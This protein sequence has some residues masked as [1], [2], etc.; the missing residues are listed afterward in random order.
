MKLHISVLVLSVVLLVSAACS[1]G[2]TPE[3]TPALTVTPSATATA[4]ATPTATAVPTATATRT[5]P[6]PTATSLPPTPTPTPEASSVEAVNVADSPAGGQLSWVL[7]AVNRDGLTE[8][9]VARH[10]TSTFADRV[11]AAQVIALFGEFRTAVEGDWMLVQTGDETDTQMV[12]LITAGG[13]EL[14]VQIVVVSDQPHLIKELS[15]SAT[16][17][18]RDERSPEPPSL[19]DPPGSWAELQK[20]LAAEASQVGLL[21]AEVTGGS[22]QPI[23]GFQ[24]D[25]ALAI[26]SIFK[27]YV[28]GELARQIDEGLASWEESLPIREDI[29][30]FG[31]LG[32][33]DSMEDEAAGILFTLKR[34]A[35][36]MISNSDNTATDHLIHRL[37]RENV[38]ASLARLGHSD[39]ALNIPFPTARELFLIKLALSPGQRAA[40][41]ELGSEGRRTFLDTDLAGRGIGDAVANVAQWVAPV[42]IDSI[43]WFASPA[44]L[45][46]AMV[47]LHEAAS[48]PG[49]EPPVRDIL[50]INPGIPLDER[51]WPFVGFKGGSEQGVLA[52]SWLLERQD[53]R[54]FFLAGILNDSTRLDRTRAYLLMSVGAELLA[55]ED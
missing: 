32:R 48:T 5:P 6:T 7:E 37:G 26:G 23:F 19:E 33:G 14:V 41:L 34:Y 36:L 46:R 31:S 10:F 13:Q 15:L 50:S 8:E 38:E 11:S 27:F 2:S 43:E 47:W 4:E 54:L 49:L 1:G 40:Y 3:P 18:Q 44:D 9:E 35:E 53:E 45:C 24:E 29:R 20:E 12:A 21:A 42:D 52:V 25:R 51:V 16:S 22:C 30:S 28:L 39:P 55:D 17:A